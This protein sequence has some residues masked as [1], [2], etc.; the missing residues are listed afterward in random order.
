VIPLVGRDFTAEDDRPGAPPVVILSHV[1]A[2]RR[3]VGARAAVGR[4]IRLDDDP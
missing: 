1:L 2:E 4:T 3:F